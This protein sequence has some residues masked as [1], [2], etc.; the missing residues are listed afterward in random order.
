MADQGIDS[1]QDD[2]ALAQAVADYLRRH[3][4]LLTARPS[5]LASLNIPHETV[6]G[7]VSLVDRQVR[8]LRE[9]NARLRFDIQRVHK[10]SAHT[11]AL[12]DRVHTLAVS[13]LHAPAPRELFE[14]LRECLREAFA[15]STLSIYVFTRPADVESSAGLRFRERD[16]RVRNLFAELLNSETPLCDSLQAEHISA[17]FGQGADNAIRSTA[18]IP[19]RRQGWDGL[20]AL[21]SREWDQ[22]AQGL[23]LDLLIYVSRVLSLSIHRWVV[24]QQAPAA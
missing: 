17:L 23:E 21:G 14:I 7:A 18:L 13:I 15:A 4:E 20:L 9:E 2:A 19:L 10:R 12:V 11:G 3:P 6:A 5:L 24:P 16:D 22:Y 1:A 8:N